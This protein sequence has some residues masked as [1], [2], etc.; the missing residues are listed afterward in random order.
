LSDKGNEAV[1]RDPFEVLVSA[2]KSPDIA[3]LLRP[4]QSVLATGGRLKFRECRWV[5]GGELSPAKWMVS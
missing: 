4:R 5:P 1:A 3:P 2:V